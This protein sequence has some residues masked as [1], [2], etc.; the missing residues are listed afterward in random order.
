MSECRGPQRVFVHKVLLA[1]SRP[2]LFTAWLLHASRPEPS[3]CDRLRERWPGAGTSWASHSVSQRL[4]KPASPA[5]LPAGVPGEFRPAGAGPPL[6]TDAARGGLRRRRAPCG[7]KA[8]GLPGPSPGR[9]LLGGPRLARVAGRDGS[10][11]GWPLWPG[12]PARSAEPCP[13]GPGPHPRLP[14]VPRAVLGG[15]GRRGNAALQQ[16]EALCARPPPSGPALD[17]PSLAAPRQ[18][19]D[20]AAGC[21][22]SGGGDR[23]VRA[24]WLPVGNRQQRGG[25]GRPF[26]PSPSA[27]PTEKR[28]LSGRRQ[29]RPR[30]AAVLPCP[31]L[32]RPHPKLKLQGGGGCVR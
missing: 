15:C 19:G 3:G 18:L 31:E 28:G 16:L 17:A 10:R 25:G 22:G 5:W 29:A 9:G 26:H 7:G 2:C 24:P 32:G 6:G 23:L 4:V 11:A 20:H 13:A 27:P 1:H 21:E 30:G 12:T 14:P 8:P